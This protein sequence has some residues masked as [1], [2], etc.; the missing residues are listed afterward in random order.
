MNIVVIGPGAL[1]SLFSAR[2][3][4]AGQ[5]VT[6]LDH[7]AQRAN[8][9]GNHLTL[10]TADQE[11]DVDLSI[12][13]D[14]ACLKQAELVILAVKSQQI[15]DLLPVVQ[16]L[17]GPERLILGLQNGIGHLHFFTDA[18]S[19]LA[20]GVTSQGATL[21]KAGSVRH[22]GDGPTVIGFLQPPPDRHGALLKKAATALSAA[23][24]ATEIVDD[25]K[26]RLWQKL[27]VNVGINGLTVLYDCPNGDLLKIPE[28]RSRLIALVEE[29]V[30]V[31]HRKGI[32][33]GTAPVGRTLE[34]CQATAGNVSSMLQDVRNGK[35]TEIM[36][37][38]GA[39]LS[40]AKKLA[41]PVSENELLVKQVLALKKPAGK[42]D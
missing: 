13:A 34:V 7:N 38:N 1:G 37:I 15:A 39:L 27:L 4:A 11:R 41:I 3:A 18:A 28:A 21:V 25:I 10:I 35:K 14:P 19:G 12:T 2:L 9:L 22:G 5:N 8:A 26:N 29:G 32:D 17:S 36:A 16:G 6:L 24:L 23:G 33:V 42:I 30:H 31:A 40:E 20:L